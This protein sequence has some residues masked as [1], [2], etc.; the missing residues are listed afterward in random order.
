MTLEDFGDPYVKRSP[1]KKKKKEEEE[2]D[3]TCNKRKDTP[4]LWLKVISQTQKQIYFN[5]YKI[6]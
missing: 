3:W 6:R 5:W 2:E 1:L 4:I